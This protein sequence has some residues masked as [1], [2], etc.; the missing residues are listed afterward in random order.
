[1]G[2]INRRLSLFLCVC[3]SVCFQYS[4]LHI[5]CLSP[6]LSPLLSCILSLW[7]YMH[8]MGNYCGAVK[9]RWLQL[10]RNKLSCLCRGGKNTSSLGTLGTNFLQRPSSFSGFLPLVLSYSSSCPP[11]LALSLTL[12]S[13]VTQATAQSHSGLL[14]GGNTVGYIHTNYT[15]K[16]RKAW[17]IF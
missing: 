14:V 16:T 5:C 2:L 8:H 7:W 17:K 15:H 9:S 12:S 13:I 1:M 6:F 10:A 11:A 3:V 4:L